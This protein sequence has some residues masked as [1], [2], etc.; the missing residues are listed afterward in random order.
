MKDSRPRFSWQALY[1]V[2]VGG[3]EVQASWQ[4][5]EIVK[6]HK[7][8]LMFYKSVPQKKVSHKS[9][10]RE[11]PTRVFLTR[12]SH[13]SVSYKIFLQKC[14]ARVPHKSVAPEFSTR[15]S[16]RSILR[17]CPARV[18]LPQECPF[19]KSVLQE[20][21]TRAPPTECPTRMHK[22]VKQC[23]ALCFRVRVR[24]RVRGFHLVY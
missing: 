8:V 6:L 7:S 19:Y 12:V 11:C 21:P 18:P 24:T 3:V 4:A 17:D 9:S 1:L 22:G 16:H 2:R 20:R 23:F 14:P 10:A 15:A 13:K 5:Q